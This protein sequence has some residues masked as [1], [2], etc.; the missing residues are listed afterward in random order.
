MT[1]DINDELDDKAKKYQCD[2][3]NCKQKGVILNCKRKC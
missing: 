3:A 2:R 1:T